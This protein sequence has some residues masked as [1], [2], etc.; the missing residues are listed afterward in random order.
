VWG[1]EAGVY[2]DQMR[3]RREQISN[4]DS[5][6][7][8]YFGGEV[9]LTARQVSPFSALDGPRAAQLLAPLIDPSVPRVSSARRCTS[10]AS[11]PTRR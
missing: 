8:L 7:K 1:V 5:P 9:G 4:L 3:A 6:Q 2:E 11:P 10:T